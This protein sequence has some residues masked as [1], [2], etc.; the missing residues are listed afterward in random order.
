MTASNLFS[1]AFM[2][3]FLYKA[4][5]TGIG[6]A[7]AYLTLLLPEG[8][9]LVTSASLRVLARYLHPSSSGFSQKS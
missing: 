5:M 9:P 2:A 1:Y 7:M 8:V 3:L 4:L 6:Y